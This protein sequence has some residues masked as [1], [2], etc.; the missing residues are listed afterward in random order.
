MESISVIRARIE[1]LEKFGLKKKP[2]FDRIWKLKKELERQEKAYEEHQ[3]CYESWMSAS[4]L[5]KEHWLN[6]CIQLQE[7]FKL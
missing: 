1:E 3:Y 7:K 2:T 6:K 5:Y 4:L